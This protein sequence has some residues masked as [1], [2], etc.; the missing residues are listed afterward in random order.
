[1]QI[2]QQPE[3]LYDW[4]Q[5]FVRTQAELET[6]LYRVLPL[7]KPASS[8][9]ITF[10]KGS[11]KFQADLTRDK[12][13]EVIQKT[14]LKWVTLISVNQNWSAFGF[15]PLGPDEPRNDFMAH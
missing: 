10:P 1:V 7:L 5:V 2:E 4:I 9:W 6:Y 15:R 11:S 14:N 13:W 12:G 8:L 3:G